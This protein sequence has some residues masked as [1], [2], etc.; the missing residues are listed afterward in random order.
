VRNALSD[1]HNNQQVWRAKRRQRFRQ[2][3]SVGGRGNTRARSR[4]SESQ[5]RRRPT[6]RWPSVQATPTIPLIAFVPTATRWH[7]YQ[8]RP[9][10]E[11]LA[12]EDLTRSGYRGYAPLIAVRKQDAVIRS[13]FHKI[14]VARFPGYGFVELSPGDPWHPILEAAGV[15]RTLRGPDG[16]PAR[17]PAFAQTVRTAV[18][19]PRDPVWPG[20]ELQLRPAISAVL[21]VEKTARVALDEVAANW[22]R[23]LK[24]SR[25]K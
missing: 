22:Q 8:T 4:R 12:A 1:E 21:L 2:H 13:L 19:E 15:A 20:M 6:R 5:Q 23:T 25:Q 17:I 24:R 14:R 18:L 3:A 7:V 10:A 11:R 16:R 9:Q